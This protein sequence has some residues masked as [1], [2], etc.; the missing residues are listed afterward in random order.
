M[1]RYNKASKAPVNKNKHD[2]TPISFDEAL[3]VVQHS[4][5]TDSDIL[6]LERLVSRGIT[7]A[8]LKQAYPI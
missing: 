4:L 3:L 6:T 5:K 1:A 7:L 2:N 8:E